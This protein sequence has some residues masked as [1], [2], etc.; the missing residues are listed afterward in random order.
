MLRV[1]ASNRYVDAHF[2]TMGPFS[3][4]ATVRVL[5][6]NVDE[7]PIFSF[8]VSRMAIS[9]AAA[10]GADVGSVLAHDPDATN[11]PIRY[12][13]KHVGEQSHQQCFNSVKSVH[14]YSIDR[15]S[16]VERYFS[17]DSS[18]GVIVTARPLDREIVALHNIT[19]LA[20]ERCK[21]TLHLTFSTESTF[22]EL[23][24]HSCCCSVDP[25]PAMKS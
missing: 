23:L 24:H 6:E 19:V 7:P 13:H 25:L 12:Q 11:S 14:R 8:A 3:D 15:K 18:S 20:T 21:S 4:V 5:V 16:D 9:E 1:E 17:I 10:V 2:L 22:L